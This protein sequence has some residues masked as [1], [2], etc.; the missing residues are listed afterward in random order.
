MNKTIEE[1]F[2]KKKLRGTKKETLKNMEKKRTKMKKK[3]TLTLRT[4]KEYISEII[5]RNFSVQ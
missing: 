2:R 5:K 1:K 3:K 4:T